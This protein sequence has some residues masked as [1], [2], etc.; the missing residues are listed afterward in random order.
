MPRT[1]FFVSDST[2]ITIENLGRALLAQFGDTGF[3]HQTYVFIDSPAK[4]DTVVAAIDYAAEQDGERPLVFATQADPELRRRL[5]RCRGLLLDPFDAF[6]AVLAGELGKKPESR[7]GRLHGIFD[8]NR[9]DS[10]M[11][12]IDFT[13][14]HDD[15]AVP[16]RYSEAELILVGPS[17]TGKTPTSLYLAIQ[18]GLRVANYPLLDEELD[19]LKLPPALRACR[20]RL[21]GLV[22]DPERLQEIRAARRPGDSDYASPARCRHE[23]EAAIA[24]FRRNAIPWLD[25]TSMSVEEIAAHIISD[26]G[27]H[28]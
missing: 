20:D 21:Y 14:R 11:A 12:A 1:V 18:Y 15:G 8:R 22:I 25:A 24:L 17:R 7:R 4:V 23:V 9:Y 26:L 2:G 10:R 5:A 27:L 19:T 28:R 3:H 16:G 6:T 13:L